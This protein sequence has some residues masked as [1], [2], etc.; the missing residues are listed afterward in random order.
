MQVKVF[1]AVCASTN[2][3][4]KVSLFH[5]VTQ[6]SAH[7]ATA[8]TDF[9]FLLRSIKVIILI[10]CEGSINHLLNNRCTTKSVPRRV[11]GEATTGNA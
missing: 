11:V 10:A 6:P 4:I 8:A 9:G 5:S 7:P 1:L 3:F 2:V